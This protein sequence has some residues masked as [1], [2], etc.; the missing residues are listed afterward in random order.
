[1]MAMQRVAIQSQTG[2]HREMHNQGGV[3][4]PW[5]DIVRDDWPIIFS[6]ASWRLL[7]HARLCELCCWTAHW[8]QCRAC[9]SVAVGELTVVLRDDSTPREPAGTLMGPVG[10][11]AVYIP[12]VIRVGSVCEGVHDEIRLP[13]SQHGLLS[14][15]AMQSIRGAQTLRGKGQRWSV[16]W[17]PSS[18]WF[19]N[20][21]C[22]TQASSYPL[23]SL[24][25][26]WI[27]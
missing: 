23:L 5:V 22:Q 16:D 25:S 17:Q 3:P 19:Y 21:G 26:P 7:K 15:T 12:A 14:S 6:F 27:T 18:T 1:M 8:L 20:F 9:M 11:N 2:C 4:Q 13:D 10:G 24:W